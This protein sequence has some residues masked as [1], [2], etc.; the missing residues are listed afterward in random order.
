LGGRQNNFTDLSDGDAIDFSW[1]H[2]A[3]FRDDALTQLTFFDNHNLDTF[4]GCEPNLNCSR[5]R[6]LELDYNDMTVK[7][8]KDYYHPEGVISGA[9]GGFE[10]APGGNV[11]IGWGLN[12]TFTEHTPDG[13]VALDV[14]Y[15]H[16]D[17]KGEGRGHYRTFKMDWTGYPPWDPAIAWADQGLAGSMVYVSWNG[18]TEVKSWE[19]VSDISQERLSMLIQD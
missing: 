6:H 5:G 1:Q 19:L 15:L 10:I 8:V 17:P 14:Q 2:D 12:P 9:M 7:V 18:A 4:I 13:E 16:W 3:Q 11:M